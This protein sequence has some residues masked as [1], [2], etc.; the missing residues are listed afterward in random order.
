MNNSLG[1][2]TQTRVRP[3][4]V[5]RAHCVYPLY[6][7]KQANRSGSQKQQRNNRVNHLSL[8]FHS[9]TSHAGGSFGFSQHIALVA[10][11]SLQITPLYPQSTLR[12]EKKKMLLHTHPIPWKESLPSVLILCTYKDGETSAK[13]RETLFWRARLFSALRFSINN[14]FSSAVSQIKASQAPLIPN[15]TPGRRGECCQAE[16]LKEPCHSKGSV[17]CLQCSLCQAPALAHQACCLYCDGRRSS[18]LFT[19]LSL[20]KAW[21]KC[22]SNNPMPALEKAARFYRA[23]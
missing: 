1:H 17:L 8:L 6:V 3:T 13:Q 21:F 23:A 15:S 7:E 19:R 20:Q 2:V 12:K 18:S 5:G 9:L 14:R 11:L 22:L 10:C 4:K 16:Q